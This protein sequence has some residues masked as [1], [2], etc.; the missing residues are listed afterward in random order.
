MIMSATVA[1]VKRIPANRKGGRYSSPILIASQVEPQMKQR[2]ANTK[3][4][5]LDSKS[6]HR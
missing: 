5:A 2:A 4:G 3:L 6:L 1:M